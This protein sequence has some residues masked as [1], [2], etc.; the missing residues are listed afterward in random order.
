MMIIRKTSNIIATRNYIEQTFV[1]LKINETL[2]QKQKFTPIWKAVHTTLFL[3]DRFISELFTK[4]D[5]MRNPP[6]Y[7]LYAQTILELSRKVINT[8]Q[9]EMLILT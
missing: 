4:N 1:S 9:K 7:K 2:S 6:V 3:Y 8:L 5:E